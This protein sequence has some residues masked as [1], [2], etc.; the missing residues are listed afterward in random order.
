MPRSCLSTRTVSRASHHRKWS[1]VVWV[2]PC[3]SKKTGM[4]RLGRRLPNCLSTDV[5]PT[6]RLSVNDQDVVGVLSRDAVLDPLENVLAT[7]EHALFGDGCAC[8]VGIDDFVHGPSRKRTISYF[9]YD[10]S[11]IIT[12]QVASVLLLPEFPPGH[13]LFT[14]S[15]ASTA[16]VRCDPPASQTTIPPRARSCSQRGT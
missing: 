7:E 13:N 1:S 6:R 14:C 11:D 2:R 16:T 4:Y 15:P 10:Y 12:C 8:N 9:R 5:F 3:R